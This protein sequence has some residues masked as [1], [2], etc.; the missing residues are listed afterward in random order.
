M[1]VDMQHGGQEKGTSRVTMVVGVPAWMRRSDAKS[2]N[3]STTSSTTYGEAT[4]NPREPCTIRH[5][6]KDSSL[7][8]SKM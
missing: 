4:L 5:A 2:I 3:A 7:V 8:V 6:P 1:M